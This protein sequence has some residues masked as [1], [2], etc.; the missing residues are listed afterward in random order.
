LKK[1][2][3]SI[4]FI[5]LIFIGIQYVNAIRARQLYQRVLNEVG[6]QEAYKP[7]QPSNFSHRFH[8]GKLKLDCKAC[9]S[10]EIDKVKDCS[11]CHKQKADSTKTINQGG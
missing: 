10:K 2:F 7:T 5:I 1:L 11:S 4:L 3:V 6:H 9:H 8:A